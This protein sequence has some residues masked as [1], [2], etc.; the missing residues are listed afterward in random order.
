MCPI[1]A[2]PDAAER[3][4]AE[5]SEF[6]WDGHGP[7]P[8][9]GIAA[10]GGGFRAMLFHAGTFVR[11]NELGI[12]SKAKRISSVS[13]GSIACGHLAAVWNDL[14]QPGSD[15]AY[16]D[17]KT[18]YLAPIHEFSRRSIDV[19]DALTGLLPWT[20]AAEEIA[21][22]YD[23]HLFA[24]RTL[25]DLPDS[26]RFVF[27]ATNLQTGV[28]WRFAKPYAGDYVV[29]RMSQPKLL[30]AEAVAASSAFPPVLS[31]LVLKLPAGSFTDWPGA[32]GPLNAVDQAAFREQI[33]LTDGGV[34]DNH[35]IEPVLKRYYTIFVSDGGA[36]F[37][38]SSELN[39]DW[40]SQLRRILDVTDN[41]VRSLRRR[42]LIDRFIS[43]NAIGSETT[44]AAQN[45]HGRLGAYWGINTDP[46]KVTPANA[47]KCDLGLVRQVAQI[48]TRL[49]DPG[50]KA[51]KQLVNWGYAICD[52]S[53]R[54]NYTGVVAPT[55]PTWPFP[56]AVLG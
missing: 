33:I 38:R 5:A 9:I 22:T 56:E 55:P 36:P 41:Q 15:G 52:R 51:A 1:D 2:M 34:Y 42:D 48:K 35:G 8:G 3:I 45:A 28:L 14:G 43:G 47:L 17:F 4:A 50:E 7:E 39:I 30:L 54:A 31:P 19:V 20:S 16:A 10:S 40:I 46:T 53:L 32:P 27:C 6:R 44:L 25:Q 11:L 26:P 18:R 23:K 29:G 37:G 12:L 13:G 24:G 49:S 21:E